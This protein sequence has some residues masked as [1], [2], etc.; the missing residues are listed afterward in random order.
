MLDFEGTAEIDATPEKVW[1]VL[2]DIANYPEWESGITAVEGTLVEGGRI[3]IH[4]PRSTPNGPSNSR[5]PN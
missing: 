2:A 1:R 5:W 4:T 3:T